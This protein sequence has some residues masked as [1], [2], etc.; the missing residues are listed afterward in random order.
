MVGR[1]QSFLTLLSLILEQTS[2]LRFTAFAATWP[3]RPQ[4]RKGRH[5][6]KQMKRQAERIPGRPG[7]LRQI[8]DRLTGGGLRALR[9]S[10]FKRA[11][12]AGKQMTAGS[13]RDLSRRL[14]TEALRSAMGRPVIRT[15]AR[16]LLQPFPE[17]SARLYRLATASGGAAGP[18]TLSPPLHRD[19]SENDTL[20]DLDRAIIRAHIAVLPAGPLIS[21][22]MPLGEAAEPV[23]R[24]SLNSV[25][26]QLYPCWELFICTDERTA[27]KFEGIV[28][29]LAEPRIQVPILNGAEDWIAQ[30][31]AAFSSVKGE[32][33][34]VLR[35]GDILPE[36]ALYEAALELGKP[37]PTDLL[38]TD[39][40]LVDP[41]GNRSSPWFKPDWDPD[42]LLA[43]DYISHLAVYRR[44][45]VEEVGFLR[46]GCQ[47]AAFHDLA[48]RTA[49]AT[50]PD[51]V[52]HIPAILCHRRSEEKALPLEN[53]WRAFRVPA[54]TNRVVRAY[55][56][57]QGFKDAIIEP[58]PL[59]PGS[60]RVIWPI[61]SPEPL[62]SVI[63][64]TRDQ[65]D[66]LSQCVEGVLHRTE[67]SHLELIIVD[68]GSVQKETLKLL[69]SFTERDARVRILRRP[70]PFNYAA[71]NNSAANEALGEVLL[72]LNNDTNVIRSDWLREMVSQAIRPDVGLVGAKLLYPNEDVQH[73]GIVLGPQGCGTH[74]RR[75][76]NRN[77]TGYFGQLA[78]VR[79]LSAVTG[80][81]AAIRRAVFLEI[82]GLDEVNLPVGFNDIDLCLRLGDYGYR[83]VWTPFAELFHLESASRGSDIA[84]KARY[85]RAL[86]ELDHLRETWGPLMESSDPFDNPNLLFAWNKFDVPASPR[87]PKPWLLVSE[88]VFKVKPRFAHP[89]NAA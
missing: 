74:F 84:H 20:S 57:A 9:A 66:L 86:R 10:L 15:F 17:L 73:A 21:V 26:T 47:E 76:A 31:N 67:Y 28:N 71:L 33:V 79:T 45:L 35:I 85:Q 61:P 7:R 13:L 34:T 48:L 56:D 81:C 38:Y 89:R 42:L 30:A 11:R 68:N 59:I 88:D 4:N 19:F 29:A 83:V 52:R 78:M 6:V 63:I 77:D 58:S 54:L 50:T 37:G 44:R 62:V 23:W 5:K 18:T 75:L 2:D 46:P 82:G 8:G 51:R 70:G 3:N 36:H 72:L 12:H 14:T 65:A 55:L 39:S 16:R 24:E 69:N 64:P 32:F 60:I 41:H 40:D 80:A 27:P 25:L 87:R 1:P 53:G 49:A 22:I 43:Q